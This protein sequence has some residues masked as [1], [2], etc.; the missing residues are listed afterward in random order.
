[1]CL[2]NKL[3]DGEGSLYIQK[4]NRKSAVSLNFTPS[5]TQRFSFCQHKLDAVRLDF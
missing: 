1:M 5:T 4:Q 3:N 2:M